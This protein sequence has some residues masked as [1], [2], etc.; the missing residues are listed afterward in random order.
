MREVGDLEKA[1]GLELFF[2]ASEGI[3]GKIR[4]RWND[5]LVME[6]QDRNVSAVDL[7]NAQKTKNTSAIH[8]ASNEK[9]RFWH[10]IMQKRGLDT[11]EAISRLARIMKVSRNRFYYSGN[12]DKKAV[13]TQLIS[14]KGPRP[15]PLFGFKGKRIS[16]LGIWPS[17][18]PVSLGSH[19]GNRFQ[20]TIRGQSHE[21]RLDSSNVDLILQEIYAQG[22]IGNFFG[23]QRFG[24]QRPVTHEIGRCIIKGDFEKAVKILVADWTPLEGNDAIEARQRIS[25]NWRP[26]KALS[27]F[28]LRL[29]YERMVLEYLSRH[30]DDYRGALLRLP[31]RLRMMYVHGIQSY[32]FNKFICERFKLGLSFVEPVERDVVA[33]ID[34]RGMPM[35]LYTV[36]N[37]RNIEKAANAIQQGYAEIVGPLVGYRTQFPENRWYERI[38]D[39]LLREQIDPEM[40]RVASCP[41]FASKGTYRPIR[42]MPVN[43]KYKVLDD[44][45]LPGQKKIIFTF[46]LPKGAY[47]TVF[48]RELMKTAPEYYV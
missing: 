31:V 5:F 43:I 7:A 2:T 25:Y 10:I 14:F 12:K 47:A 34:A 1:I 42:I 30:P 23:H 27:Y 45:M 18:K 36:V 17:R 44:E 19:W 48:L 29:T 8:L 24:V 46:D 22:G 6:M 28:P 40:F 35:K 20:I 37:S 15:D 3:G 21:D 4:V 11:P 38:K 13:T 26:K 39:I 16:I 41:T 32:L 9:T 33:S